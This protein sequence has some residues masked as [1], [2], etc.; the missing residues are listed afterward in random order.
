M[1]SDLTRAAI[2]ACGI[3]AKYEGEV[4]VYLSGKNVLAYSSIDI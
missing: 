3:N 4:K 2:V 1:W